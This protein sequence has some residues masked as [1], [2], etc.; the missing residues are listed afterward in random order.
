MGLREI[1]YT[2]KMDNHEYYTSKNRVIHYFDHNNLPP[3]TPWS[4]KQPKEIYYSSIIPTV[5]AN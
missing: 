3:P 5:I 1:S 4:K 2:L